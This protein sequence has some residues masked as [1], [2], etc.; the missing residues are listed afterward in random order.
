MITT[1][2]DATDA[3]RSLYYTDPEHRAQAVREHRAVLDALRASDRS[4]V[5]AW[6]DD[7]RAHAVE[8]LRKVL[9]PEA[10]A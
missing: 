5:L 6:L 10:G 8:A 4:S 3:Y 9:P 7:H 1:L 2:W